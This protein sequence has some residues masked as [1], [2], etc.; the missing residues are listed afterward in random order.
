MG[1]AELILGDAP[2]FLKILKLNSGTFL[3]SAKRNNDVRTKGR[4]TRNMFHWNK[5][6]IKSSQMTNGDYMRVAMNIYNIFPRI[7]V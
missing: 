3:Q 4:F 7:N 6:D 2:N 5:N 1:E